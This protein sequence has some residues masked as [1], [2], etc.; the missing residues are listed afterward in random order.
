[1]ARHRRVLFVR[2]ARDTP[3]RRRATGRH[4]TAARS[5]LPAPPHALPLPTLDERSPGAGASQGV[6]ARSATPDPTSDRDAH[7]RSGVRRS[8]KPDPR[9]APRVQGHAW[10]HGRRLAA[11]PGSRPLQ[12][13]TA[14]GGD[15]ATG[16]RASGSH[17]AGRQR[18]PA[19]R[20]QA[21]SG[22]YPPQAGG[23]ANGI[24]RERNPTE[25]A[26]T[27]TSVDT[28]PLPRQQATSGIYP[29]QAGEIANGIPRERNPTEQARRAPRRPRRSP[30]SPG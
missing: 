20:Q 9:T 15:I 11:A 10:R 25:Q 17:R 1:M 26:R 2:H 7:Q 29:P 6:W 22:I 19:A 21:T 5:Q 24:P 14:A 23:T 8:R 12:G 30:G 18:T 3:S 27:A 4:P 28:W 13:S 16:I